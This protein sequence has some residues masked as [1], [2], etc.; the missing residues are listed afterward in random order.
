MVCAVRL[1]E[2]SYVRWVMCGGLHEVDHARG[3]LHEVDH[4]RWVMRGG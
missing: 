2:V 3:G 4:A 1:C